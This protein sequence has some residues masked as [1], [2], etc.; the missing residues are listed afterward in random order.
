MRSTRA[1]NVMRRAAGRVRGG[2]AG[3]LLLA[4]LPLAAAAE[5]IELTCQVLDRQNSLYQPD[6]ITV[7]INPATLT[8][9][10]SDDVVTA[11][12]ASSVAGNVDTM[13]A[14]RLTVVWTVVGAKRDP[15]L[16]T[17]GVGVMPN[18]SQRLTILFQAGEMFLQTKLIASSRNKY[19]FRSAL[20]CTGID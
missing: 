5:D 6:R 17:L 16:G 8:A 4:A 2:L 18:V 7:R 11:T 13:N 3:A 9:R 14:K 20:A 19:E 10:V 1:E 12:G 15:K